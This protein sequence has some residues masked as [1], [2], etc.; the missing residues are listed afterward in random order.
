MRMHKFAYFAA[1]VATVG[2]LAGTP[3]IAAPV[4]TG[5]A[6]LNSAVTSPVTQARWWG[7]GPGWGWRGGYWR[8]PGWYWGGRGWYWGG[9]AAGAV[10]GGIIASQAY[11]YPGPAYYGAPGPGPGG[12]DW[13]AYCSSRYRTF[14]PRTGTYMGYDGHRHPCR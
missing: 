9:V 7:R 2:M 11:R 13:L 5:A 8:G 10:A 6:S 3:A 1:A 4:S 14:D 12:E